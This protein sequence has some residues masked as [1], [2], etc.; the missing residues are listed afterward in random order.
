MRR[1]ARTDRNHLEIVAALRK[2][3]CTVRSLAAVGQG[4]PD[5]LVAF[6]AIDGRRVTVLMEV[7]DGKKRPSARKLT[8]D[9]ARF[10]ATWAGEAYVVTSVEEAIAV[11]TRK[12]A[13]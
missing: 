7:K 4:C 5:L 1:A 6:T 11:V 8:P 2:V 10:F 3:G 9:E 13:A 12:G